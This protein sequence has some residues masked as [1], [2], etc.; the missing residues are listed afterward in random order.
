MLHLTIAALP[1]FHSSSPL[2]LSRYV[3]LSKILKRL[4]SFL[5]GLGA[6]SRPSGRV[7]RTVGLGGEPQVNAPPLFEVGASSIDPKASLSEIGRALVRLVEKVGS[8]TRATVA[9]NA[10]RLCLRDVGFSAGAVLDFNISGAAGAATLR[11]GTDCIGEGARRQ[12]ESDDSELCDMHDAVG[13][14]ST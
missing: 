10:D 11:E 7:G 6:S 9:K 2:P 4:Y 12:A 1:R 13:S 3:S 8:L 14:N 5:E